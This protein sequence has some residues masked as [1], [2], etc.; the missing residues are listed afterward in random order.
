MAER[1]NTHRLTQTEVDMIADGLEV[2]MDYAHRRGQRAKREGKQVLAR[3]W[4]DHVENLTS[5]RERF[6]TT[7]SVVITYPPKE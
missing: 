4:M 7:E 6:F 3:G 2:A 5:L 1:R